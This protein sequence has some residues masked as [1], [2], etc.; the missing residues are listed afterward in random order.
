[1]AAGSTTAPAATGHTTTRRAA[2]GPVQDRRPTSSNSPRAAPIA[3]QV[4]NSAVATTAQTAP[5]AV[6]SRLPRS[7]SRHPRSGRSFGVATS[8]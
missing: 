8:Q 1:M 7:A 2:T 4:A 6:S 3:D 5:T